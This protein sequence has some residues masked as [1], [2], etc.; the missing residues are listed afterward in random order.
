VVRL[1]AMQI[2]A[3]RRLEVPEDMQSDSALRRLAPADGQVKRN[4]LGYNAARHYKLDLAAD[5][6]HDGIGR[7]KA[8]YLED[9]QARTNLSYGYVVPRG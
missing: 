5:L 1:A 8:A 6:D 9:G 3:F 4:I 7:I 2:E